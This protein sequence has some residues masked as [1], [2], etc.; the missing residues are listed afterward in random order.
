MESKEPFQTIEWKEEYK[1]NVSFIDEHHRK[2]IEIM[3]LF[4]EAR[5]DDFCTDKMSEIFFSL[6]HYAEDYLLREIIFFKE[7]PNFAHHQN[8]H[9]EFIERINKF[10]ADYREGKKG[11][12]EEMYFYLYDWFQN[13]ILKYDKEAVEYLRSKGLT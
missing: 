2:F 7:Y 6:A 5:K 8:A 12:C 3:N 4:Q 1:V 9:S 11:V 13:H 10:Q